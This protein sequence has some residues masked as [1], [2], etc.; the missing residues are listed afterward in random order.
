MTAFAGVRGTGDWGP[1]ERP[2][3]F[4]EGILWMKPN[5]MAPM[6]AL[7]ARMGKYTV[8]DPEFSWWDEPS[9]LVRLQINGAL[10]NNATDVVV[11]SSDPSASNLD[12]RWGTALNLVPGDLLMVEPATDAAILN[13][14]VLKV[15]TVT[16]A[17]AFSVTRAGAG[18]TAA[19]IPDNT[20]LLKI[21]STFSE[22]TRSPD[23]AS[24]NPVK[25]V[26]KAQIFKTTYE[27]TGTAMQ[28][29]ART[30]DPL[31]NDKRRK[32][33]DH[34]RD[35]ETAILFG[36]QSETIGSNGKP[37]RTMGGLRS[38][39]PSSVLTADWSMPDLLDNVSTVFDWD[40]EAGDERM[41]FC[42]NGA[43][44]EFNKKLEAQSGNAVRIN[45]DGR[46]SM[47]GVNFRRYIVPQGELAIKTHPLL[48][49]HPLYNYSWWIVDGSAFKWCPLRNRDTKFKDNVQHNDEDTKKG[50]WMT[51]AGIMVDRG[52]LTMKYIGGFN[53]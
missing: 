27:L 11:D 18:T 9:D 42:G 22:G 43:L 13:T 21:G 40:S 1:D 25:Y 5:G 14:E 30:G 4:R 26:N 12:S 2:R 44:N 37:E 29:R 7:S 52:G 15:A 39:I 28:T 32:M 36:R 51:E 38:F 46:M 35:I 8:D 23:S 20:Y 41:V 3:S 34:S 6:F 48:T 10:S 19:A 53:L 33:F 16:S 49:R 45:Y 17:T 47:Y 31:K 50:Q 24:R